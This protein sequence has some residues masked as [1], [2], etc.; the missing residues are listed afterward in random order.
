MKKQKNFDMGARD[1]SEFA[2]DVIIDGLPAPTDLIDHELRNE[3]NGTIYRSED[4]ELWS[5]YR[6]ESEVGPDELGPDDIVRAYCDLFGDR[7]NIEKSRRVFEQ[8]V[9]DEDIPQKP[10]EAVEQALN[11]YNGIKNYESIIKN[12][13]SS[14]DAV[15][16]DFLIEPIADKPYV[17]MSEESVDSLRNGEKK[18]RVGESIFFFLNTADKNFHD[19]VIDEVDDPELHINTYLEDE[20]LVLELYDNGPGIDKEDAKGIF[21]PEFGD[22]TGLPTANYIIEEYGGELD[23]YDEEGEFG[24]KARFKIKDS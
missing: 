22:S 24:L 1:W 7:E 20:A 5:R 15:S 13:H 14:E 9:R 16:Y 6:S 8:A 18:I 19:S 21:E 10:R 2:W 23:L 12:E 4:G 3:F 17:S 11:M